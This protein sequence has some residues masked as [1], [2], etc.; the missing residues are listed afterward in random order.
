[1]SEEIK[2]APVFRVVTAARLFELIRQPSENVNGR[3]VV[4]RENLQFDVLDGR[5]FKQEAV[6]ALQAQ[7]LPEYMRCVEGL[8]EASRRPKAVKGA[9]HPLA[10]A[11]KPPGPEIA[12]A[13]WKFCTHSE[14]NAEGR[15]AWC[16]LQLI[17]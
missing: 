1:M 17:P 10:N 13:A 3:I 12:N 16:G 5:T 6:L 14:P 15:C 8:L 11:Y 7:E 2:P 9:G 4:G